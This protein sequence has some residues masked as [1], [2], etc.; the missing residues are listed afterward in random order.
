V[1]PDTSAMDRPAEGRRFL[2]RRTLAIAIPAL[3]LLLGGAIVFPSL[4]RWL[5]SERSAD[6]A[7]LRLGEVARGDLERDL[8]VEGRIVAAFHPTLFS[9]AQGIV[10][11]AVKAGETV[12]RGQALARV[13][14][15]DLESRRKQ[16][17]SSLL[18][19]ESD[20]ARQRILAR[21]DD[22]E[23]RQRIDLLGVKV[24]AAR[25]ALDR[26]RR[27]REEGILNDVDYEKAE[28]DLR[29]A[30]L[31][32][33]HARGK[34]QL[35]AETLEAE[36]RNRELQVER[37][38][39]VL[40]DVARQI[41]DLTI[42]A[43][44]DGL[45]SRLDVQDRDAVTPGRALV[46]VVDLSAFEI[47]I[48]VPE[49]YADE[50]DPG[51]PAVV[52][53]AGGDYQGEVRSLS[54]EVQGSQVKGTVAFSGVAPQGLKQN[55]RVPVRLVLESK[56]GVLK[57]ARG[58]FLESGGGRQAYVVDG[59][60][61]TLRTIQVGALSVAEVEVLSGL[62]VGEQIIISDTTRFEGATTI[63]LH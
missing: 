25:R 11:L 13:E 42:R 51:T 35:A 60:R 3:L 62:E 29:L 1:I 46:T 20:L 41:D 26:A 33:D 16:E 10:Q 50:I 14:S 19:L 36:T 34:A 15:P 7:R 63:Y 39:L 61:A 44:F 8:A 49:T 9:P 30:T 24:E 38:K 12:S 18:S 31:E 57:V 6:L 23:N 40:Q 48:N 17:Q 52:R 59:D 5:G 55:Q 28:D 56:T 22:L 43:P 27:I 58:P 53:Y 32:L 45:L 47:E 54:P 37:Q 21:E 4:S 2:S